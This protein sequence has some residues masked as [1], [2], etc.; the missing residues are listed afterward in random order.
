MTPLEEMTDEQFQEHVM[1]VLGKELGLYGLA[2]YIRLN[3]SGT[4]DYTRDRHKWLA[5][6]TIDDIVRD[7]EKLYPPTT[8][9]REAS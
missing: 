9:E 1:D 2:R 4:G 6:V 3:R 5:G 7:S 8:V